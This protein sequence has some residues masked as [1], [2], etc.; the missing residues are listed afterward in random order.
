M[1]NPY[2]LDQIVPASAFMLL[3]QRFVIDS[4][5]T[6]NVVYDKIIADGGKVRRMLPSTLDVLF[7][8][9]N[10]A[11]AQLLEPELKRYG[12][13]PNLGALRYLVDSYEPE[14]WNSTLYNGWLNTIRSLNAPQ[15]RSKYPAFMQTAA[16][17]QQKM[18]TQ[19]ASWAQLRHDNLLY[20]KQSYTGG[21]SC[22]FPKSMVEPIPEFYASVKEYASQ[23]LTKFEMLD[24]GDESRKKGVIDHFTTLRD[25]AATLQ[26]IAVKELENTPLTSDEEHFLKGMIF[27]KGE[28][29]TTVPDGWYPHLFYSSTIFHTNE[30]GETIEDKVVADV[31]T[32]PTDESGNPVG[33]VLH[34]GTGPIDLAVVISCGA[35]DGEPVAFIGPVMSYYE[36]V[37]TGFKRLTDEEWKSAYAIEPSFRPDFVNIYLAT[38]RGESRGEGPMLTSGVDVKGPAAAEERSLRLMENYP[39]PFGTSTLI[40][41]VVPQELAGR[42]GELTIFDARGEPVRHLLHRTLPAAAYTSEWDGTADDGSAAPDGVYIYR[43]KV[44][45]EQRSGKMTLVRSGK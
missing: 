13:A 1:S 16:W 17:W 10:N 9:G 27:E 30:H 31:H 45:D 41:F 25:V 34:A 7:A 2:D 3:G 11:A 29:C 38:D 44:G 42:D 6:G 26:A 4:Y 18:N 28:G 24:M 23:A 36:H 22:S 39:N 43:L 12:Y 14:F 35:P 15:E 33:W 20:A 19:L 21:V 8:L 32:A 40:G 37:S 5:I